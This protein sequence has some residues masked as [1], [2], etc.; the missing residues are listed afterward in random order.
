M[1]LLGSRRIPRPKAF[2]FSV[3]RYNGVMLDFAAR[4][5][6][7]LAELRESHCAVPFDCGSKPEISGLRYRGKT[8]LI[9]IKVSRRFVIAES[10]VSGPDRDRTDDLLNAIEST[11]CYKFVM[12][13]F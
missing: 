9:E 8:R 10:R 4:F 6:R 7:F 11:I 13:G 5:N 1:F 2:V 12:I 3:D